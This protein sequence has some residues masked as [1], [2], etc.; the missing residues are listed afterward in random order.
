[1]TRFAGISYLTGINSFSFRIC[2]I[3]YHVI[4]NTSIRFLYIYTL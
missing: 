4:Q 3:L 1:M 2:V